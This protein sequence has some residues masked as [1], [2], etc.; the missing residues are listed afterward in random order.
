MSESTCN[1][2]SVVVN[3]QTP[4]TDYGIEVLWNP[5]DGDCSLGD[6]E[7]MLL[8]SRQRWRSQCT[9]AI[10]I[11]IFILPSLQCSTEDWTVESLR[12][13]LRADDR[14]VQ[15]QVDI[16]VDEQEVFSVSGILSIQI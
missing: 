2:F 12:F 13:R 7:Q 10:I 9:K 4:A 8:G 11:T 5:D 1:G 3:R 16:Y 14:T 15:H 6:Y